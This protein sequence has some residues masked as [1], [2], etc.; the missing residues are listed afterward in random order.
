MNDAMASAR[1]D[2]QTLS[3]ECHRPNHRPDAVGK[4]N[5]MFPFGREIVCVGLMLFD[6]SDGATDNVPS[7]VV[8]MKTDAFQCER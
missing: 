3:I 4:V 7:G 2:K 6:E 5:D 1:K 8:A